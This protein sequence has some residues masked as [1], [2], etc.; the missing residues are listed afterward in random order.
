M[1]LS[2]AMQYY[3]PIGI[4]S[5]ILSR[6]RHL[7]REAHKIAQGL[8]DIDLPEHILDSFCQ[9]VICMTKL[10]GYKYPRTKHKPSAD[11]RK[12]DIMALS[13]AGNYAK[14]VV[15][16]TRMVSEENEYTVNY[17]FAKNY[18]TKPVESTP[19]AELDAM[20]KGALIVV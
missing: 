15:Q 19:K 1:V 4:S 3:D 5:P 16:Y 10:A 14:S 13:D 8:W 6:F 11:S 9:L 17:L 12:M 7:V 2:R 20:F 18:L